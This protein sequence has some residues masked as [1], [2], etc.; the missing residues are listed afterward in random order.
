MIN[1]DHRQPL[2]AN[3]TPCP[4]NEASLAW[5][6]ARQVKAGKKIGDLVLLCQVSDAAGCRLL[7]AIHPH[8][9]SLLM[10][11]LL[12]LPVETTA[13]ELLDFS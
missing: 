5:R 12:D 7:N 1:L 8:L 4:K 2:L 10:G 9:P 11:V 3:Y 6:W 13:F